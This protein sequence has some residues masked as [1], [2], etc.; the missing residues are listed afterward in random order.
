MKLQKL[1]IVSIIVVMLSAISFDVSSLKFSDTTVETKIEV[2][3]EEKKSETTFDK[4][5]I[6][7]NSGF[8]FQDINIFAA[9]DTFL[10]IVN[11]LYLN[12]IFKP[13]IF[14]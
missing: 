14:S 3:V 2:S 11:Q 9:Y 10:P 6:L 13:P 1:Y 12:D 4:N 5:F 8:N 7:G